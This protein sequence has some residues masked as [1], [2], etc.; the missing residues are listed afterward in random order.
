MS[1]ALYELW[2]GLARE[3][4]VPLDWAVAHAPDGDLAG[5]VA[6]AW[7]ECADDWVMV[8]AAL[9]VARVLYPDVVRAREAHWLHDD[10][11]H[12]YG[13]PCCA[14]AIAD[15]VT[16]RDFATAVLG[17]AEGALSDTARPVSDR[18]GEDVR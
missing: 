1:E 2:P 3:R 10:C 16:G 9:R 17:N 15:M 6:R 7:D 12:R 18:G 14:A 13:S 11:I 5:A 8:Q 4:R